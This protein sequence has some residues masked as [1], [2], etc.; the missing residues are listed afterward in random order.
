MKKLVC[1][2]GLVGMMSCG[3]PED[4][5][6]GPTGATG[7]QG[8]DGLDNRIVYQINCIGTIVGGLWDGVDIHWQASVTNAGDVFVN[9]NVYSLSQFNNSNSTFY[10]YKQNGA[11][12][13]WISVILDNSTYVT[14]EYNP[15]TDGIKVEFK[16]S[17]PKTYID[18]NEDTCTT[19]NF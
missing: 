14:A 18:A 15:A 8:K 12:K 5:K 2:L 11:K 7:P 16:G 10:S 6:P 13:G 19:Q 9:L 1:L 3:Q 17:Y 4:G